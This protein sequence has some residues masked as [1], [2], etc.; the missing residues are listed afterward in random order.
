MACVVA[1]RAGE[2]PGLRVGHGRYGRPSKRRAPSFVICLYNTM[3]G[4]R[5]KLQIH[6]WTLARAMARQAVKRRADI[7]ELERRRWNFP[8][9]ERRRASDR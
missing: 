6:R 2:L 4:L 8:T 9:H 1:R 5:S 3:P 7:Y